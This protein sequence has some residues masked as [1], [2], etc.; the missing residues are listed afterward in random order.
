MQVRAQLVNWGCVSFLEFLAAKKSLV[1]LFYA[2]SSLHFRTRNLRALQYPFPIQSD[3]HEDETRVGGDGAAG[4]DVG[5]APDEQSAF[6][7]GSSQIR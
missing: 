1:V 4:S 5:V 6:P 2:L 7:Y 3:W